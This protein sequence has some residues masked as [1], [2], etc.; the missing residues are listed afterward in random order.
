MDYALINCLSPSHPLHVHFAL[1]RMWGGWG[2]LDGEQQK[3]WDEEHLPSLKGKI[4]IQDPSPSFAGP[5]R[6]LSTDTA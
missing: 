6:A 5:G 3:S 4:P 1:T 2:V